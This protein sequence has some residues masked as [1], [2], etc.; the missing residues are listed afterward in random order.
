V[1]C[2]NCGK[3]LEA[4]SRFCAACGRP[5]GEIEA[6]TNPSTPPAIS[7]P[8]TAVP[9]SAIHARAVPA[10]AVPTSPPPSTTFPTK[11]SRPGG[12]VFIMVLWV[13][14]GALHV[15]GGILRIGGGYVIEL[16]SAV[17]LV[18]L[19]LHFWGTADEARNQLVQQSTLEGFV[20]FLLAFGYFYVAVNLWRLR[21][22]TGRL[23][24]IV[25]SVIVPLHSIY[26]MNIGEGS[27]IWHVIAIVF[28]AWVIYY[29]CKP[30]VKRSF[31]A[32]DYS[33]A[34]SAS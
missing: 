1:Y 34:A 24:A 10:R 22:M 31:A 32:A 19:V 14:S 33:L 9:A 16:L 27:S 2:T 30:S 28:N 4:G 6:A 13:L 25:F 23:A 17:P 15:L 21:E 3:S 5:A 12:V 29:L 8:A 18:H 11:R 26:L 7:V 20:L